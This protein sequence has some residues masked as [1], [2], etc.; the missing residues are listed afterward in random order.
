MAEN[1]SASNGSN[2]SNNG[3]NNMSSSSNNGSN[4]SNN[5]FASDEEYVIGGY[6]TLYNGEYAITGKG[7][8]YKRFERPNCI[9][10]E[11]WTNEEI[12]VPL[13]NIMP[14]LDQRALDANHDLWFVKRVSS[15]SRP[16]SN[17][18]NSNNSNS[19]YNSNYNS[20]N[21]NNTAVETLPRPKRT[22][23]RK[24][25]KTRKMKVRKSR[26]SRKSRNRK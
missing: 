14:Y 11:P 6:Y 25:Q 18:Y 15:L 7:V 23:Y 22:K 5:T 1:S 21:S 3:S 17:S 13:G 24:S 8:E 4:A 26:K 9:F 20:Y 16:R 12:V 19:D 2:G 10:I